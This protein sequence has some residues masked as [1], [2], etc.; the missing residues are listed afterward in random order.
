MVVRKLRVLEAT[1]E[2]EDLRTIYQRL[3]G[4]ELIIERN[5]EGNRI[6]EPP[7]T[8]V[9]KSKEWYDPDAVPDE[10]CDDLGATDVLGFIEGE[11]PH[12]EFILDHAM[13]YDLLEEVVLE[14]AGLRSH[15]IV[16]ALSE[17][18]RWIPYCNEDQTEIAEFGLRMMWIIEEDYHEK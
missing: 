12:V 3:T 9:V 2:P 15:N 18:N 8:L 16:K 7:V 17:R 5:A 10:V 11:E 1:F 6:F 4:F 14:A 13:F